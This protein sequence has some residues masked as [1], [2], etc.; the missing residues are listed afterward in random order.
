M[1]DFEKS[2]QTCIGFEGGY[3]DDPDDRGGET[4]FGISKRAYPAVDIKSLTTDDARQIYF[5][6]YWN[7]LQLGRVL[8][9]ALACEI[10]EQ[11]VNLGK[12]QAA[13]HLQQALTMIGLAVAVDGKVGPETI[14]KAN[15]AATTGKKDV[16]LKALNGLQFMRYMEIVRS[17][18]GQKKFFVGWL[19]RVG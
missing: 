11:A 1:S 15:L 5:N 9:D 14:G 12:T 3:A 4:K 7:P 18:P 17:D 8:D 19:R 13:L 10:F 16:L 6:D 2:F